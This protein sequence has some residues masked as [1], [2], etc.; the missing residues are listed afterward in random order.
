MESWLSNVPVNGDIVHDPS[1]VLPGFDLKRREWVILNRFRTTQSKCAHMMHSL[2]YCDSPVCDCGF[3]KQSTSQILDCPLS[4]FDSDWTVLYQVS[5]EAFVYLT[6]LDVDLGP[7]L[8][9]AV[10]SI[11]FR[12]M[13]YE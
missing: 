3:A 10:S 2:G 1:S 5:S 8:R 9:P 12:F 11:F 7:I 4:L 6:N 13:S